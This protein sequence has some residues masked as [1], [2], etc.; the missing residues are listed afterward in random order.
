MPASL[1]RSTRCGSAFGH[2]LAED[3]FFIEEHDVATC[4]AGDREQRYLQIG[5]SNLLDAEGSGRPG[6]QWASILR[7]PWD[8]LGYPLDNPLPLL[9]RVGHLLPLWSTNRC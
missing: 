4:A 6:A 1:V 7:Q 8:T 9:D 5:D 3:E 2:L